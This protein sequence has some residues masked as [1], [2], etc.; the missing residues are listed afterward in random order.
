MTIVKKVA[1]LRDWIALKTGAIR[2]PMIAEVSGYAA[3]F[4]VQSVEEIWRIRDLRG[5]QDV[6]RLLL[7]EAEE[8][9]V[10]WDVGSN[11]GTHACICSTKANVFAFEPNP[12]TFDR[13]TENS[14]RAPGTVIPLRYGLSSSSGDISFEPS[15]IA[16]NGTH[17]VST[18]GSMTIKTISGDELVESGEVPKPNVVK[19]DVEGHELEVLKGMTNALQ[20]VNF[21]IVEIHAGVDP[22]DVTKLL[23]EAKLSTEITKLNRD[24]DFVIGRRQND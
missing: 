11:I 9:D 20:S 24:E 2:S 10:L 21:V 4:T 14:D 6:I 16:A 13:L 12:D 1:R 3:R 7:E 19:V 15:P 18:E 5:E 22:K 8:D 17:K 23:S